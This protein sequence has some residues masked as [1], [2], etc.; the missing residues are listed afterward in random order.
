MKLLELPIPRSMFKALPELVIKNIQLKQEA[1]QIETLVIGH[2]Q[3]GHGFDPLHFPNSFN[4]CTR[5]QDA[6][7]SYEV[8]AKVGATLPQ[9]KRVILFYSIISPGF[10]T[11]K[12]E[13]ERTIAVAFNEVFKLGAKFAD[14]SLDL[15]A[16][17]VEGLFDNLNWNFEADGYSAHAG[18]VK[19]ENGEYFDNT[20]WQRRR[21]P[22]LHAFNSLNDAD[23]YLGKTIAL[24]Q[25]RGHRIYFVVAPN[26]SDT[27]KG[28][29]GT[30]AHLHRHLLDALTKF[31]LRAEDVYADLY[32]DTRFLDEYFADFTHLQ[33]GAEG[34]ELMTKSIRDMVERAESGPV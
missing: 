22:Q 11:E 3:G 10:L 26:R 30:P 8:Y 19:N 27:V 14:D 25:E 2:S 33:M 28:V 12:V 24:A 6:K 16:T 9:L 29:P 15:L 20:Y 32:C 23:H 31:N 18:Y 5:S 4:L 21:L 34:S 17:D 7:M 1:D 13:S